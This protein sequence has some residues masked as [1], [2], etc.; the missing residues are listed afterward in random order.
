MAACSGAGRGAERLIWSDC[1]PKRAG[2]IISSP[3][4]D[5][6]RPECDNVSRDENQR[7]TSNR[8]WHSGRTDGA[9]QVIILADSDTTTLVCIQSHQLLV[10]CDA[11]GR[12]HWLKL[13]KLYKS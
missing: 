5:R 2:P 8:Y 10:G 6:P 4:T 7:R 1:L 12:L 9:P 13:P 3:A 11:S